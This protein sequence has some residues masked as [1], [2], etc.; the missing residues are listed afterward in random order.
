MNHYV[1]TAGFMLGKKSWMKIDELNCIEINSTFYHLPSTN[2]VSSWSNYPENV[3][4][5]I[6][7][8]KYI[9]H[10][11]RLKDVESHWNTFWE[12]IQP[13][14]NKILSVL[15]QLPPSFMYSEVNMK[16]IM[17]IKKYFPININ[18]VVEFRNKSWL[19]EY[20][21]QRMEDMAIIICGTY[22]QRSP[23]TTNWLGDMPAGLNFGNVFDKIGYMR[24]HG[25]K[26]YKGELTQEQLVD[27][28]KKIKISNIK[29][30]II[31]FNNTFFK[32]KSHT[33]R[34]NNVEIKYAAV[35][36]AVLMKRLIN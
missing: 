17:D 29:N 9:T 1:G 8:S 18:M 28:Y 12:R 4:I 10:T 26:G 25:M 30:Q 15:F 23:R 36:N 21:Y 6:K 33:I 34:I 3:K 14:Q 13:C 5:S 20:V 2:I 31:I 19:T 27:L 16:R 24:I 22:I 32:N 35:Y 11:K 7:A